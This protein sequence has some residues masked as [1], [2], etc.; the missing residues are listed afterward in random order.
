MT[1][2]EMGREERLRPRAIPLAGLLDL[3]VG[4]IRLRR[5]IRHVENLDPHLRR[6]VGLENIADV[7][8]ALREGRTL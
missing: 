5:T 4:T 3:L 7:R 1:L 8:R 2:L 6:D